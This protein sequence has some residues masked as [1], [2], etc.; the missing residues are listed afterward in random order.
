M[1]REIN[2]RTARGSAAPFSCTIHGGPRMTGPLR[3]AFDTIGL[4]LCS[5]QVGDRSDLKDIDEEWGIAGTGHI[6]RS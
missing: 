5:R 2:S 6:Q 1:T 3:L 4:L